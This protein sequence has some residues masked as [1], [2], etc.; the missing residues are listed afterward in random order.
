MDIQFYNRYTQQIESEIVYGEKWLRRIYETKA[1]KIALAAFVKRHW[2]SNY[3][4]KKM[5]APKSREKIIPFLRDYK[6][7]PEDYEKAPEDFI[8]FNDFF[9][10]KIKEEKRPVDKAPDTLV[11]PADGRHLGYQAFSENDSIFTKGSRFRLAD[12]LQDDT[13]TKRF[14]GGSMIIS[15]LCPVDYHRYHFCTAGIPGETRNINGWLYSVSP[16]ALR[17]NIAYLVQ[18]KRSVTEI[19][20]EHCG[21]ILQL[22]IGATCVGTIMQTYTPG[23]A[24]EKGEEKGYFRFGGSCV[25]TLFE[26]DRVQLDTDLVQHTKENRELYAH[27]GDHCAKMR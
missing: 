5:D 1:G 4:G 7:D 9:Y 12:L 10:R 14:L 23:K 19:K 27:V 17:R 25:I 13:L 2:F 8:S 11:F 24:V 6:L 26:P 20:T 22:E 18:N 16:I 15:R 21:S 3:Y